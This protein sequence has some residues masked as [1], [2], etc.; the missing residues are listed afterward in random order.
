M[1]LKFETLWKVAQ[2]LNSR[3]ISGNPR[4][5]DEDLV[6]LVNKYQES[7]VPGSKLK[8]ILS[9]EGVL[10]PF[11]NR[12]TDKVEFY[13]FN[14]RA[15]DNLKDRYEDEF[16][17]MKVGSCDEPK[18]KGI[19]HAHIE[20]QGDGILFEYLRSL[21][22]EFHCGSIIPCK[23]LRLKWNH[24]R[25]SWAAVRSKVLEVLEVVDPNVAFI[26]FEYK[27]PYN[28]DQ[29]IKSK[30][31]KISDKV[32]YSHLRVGGTPSEEVIQV[33]LRNLN[34]PLKDIL[35]QL[36]SIGYTSSIHELPN[37][38]NSWSDFEFQASSKTVGVK[39]VM[40]NGYP[41]LTWYRH[42]YLGIDLPVFHQPNTCIQAISE[43][44][45]TSNLK[46]NWKVVFEFNN[47][48]KVL[49]LEFDK[50]DSGF[51]WI[52]LEHDLS[53]LTPICV[54][55]KTGIQATEALA[56]LKSVVDMMCN[57]SKLLDKI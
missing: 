39:S 34:H 18:M 21:E 46:L 14:T 4:P 26:K 41:A 5:T 6:D 48:Q 31:L 22:D 36:Q 13:T 35:A 47:K 12:Y 30:G 38:I 3:A 17:K 16:N 10:Y 54:G 19:T 44:S 40:L 53:H 1:K 51:N 55:D 9:E 49:Q 27:L 42:Q 15:L 43:G 52:N 37:V 7:E 56:S 33:I 11:R 28:W 23:A 24:P 45:Y 8:E 29:I 50:F 32:R 25:I 57:R 2:E 20:R